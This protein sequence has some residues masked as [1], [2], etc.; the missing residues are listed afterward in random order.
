MM[1]P[2]LKTQPPHT[3]AHAAKV[4]L[5]TIVRNEIF[6]T[7]RLGIFDVGSM[8]LKVVSA[9]KMLQ[10]I[11]SAPARMIGLI[12]KEH[13]AVLQL[14][15]VLAKKANPGVMKTVLVNV[16]LRK[17]EITN[18]HVK[19]FGLEDGARKLLILATQ[20][21]AHHDVIFPGLPAV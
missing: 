18:A 12:E 13:L 11:E 2:V 14:T 15:H 1:E 19:H 3:H 20:R 5:V 7:H 17:M 16:L 6:A 4:I 8:V 9:M 10:E 21:M